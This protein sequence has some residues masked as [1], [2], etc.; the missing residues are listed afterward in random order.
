M[1]CFN[2]KIFFISLFFTSFLF[3]LPTF[4]ND[5]Y[6]VDELAAIIQT[7]E[8]FAGNFVSE[9]KLFI[10]HALFKASYKISYDYG[11]VIV[12][13]ATAFIIFL[14]GVSIYFIGKEVKSEKTGIY[15]AF[16]Y[17]VLISSF[18][19]HFMATN[20]EII[21]NLPISSGI[22]F[23]I[24]AIKNFKVQK[25]LYVFLST[26]AYFISAYVATNVK[27]HGIILIII[28]LFYTFA[29]IPYIMFSGKNLIKY[30]ISFTFIISIIFTLDI[31]FFQKIYP[32]LKSIMIGKLFYSFNA[33][34]MN[35]FYILVKYSHRQLLLTL[36][37]FVLWIPVF[38]YLKNLIF[39][40]KFKV[41]IIESI[42]VSYF[43]LTYLMVFGGG[44]RL[45]FHYFMAPYPAACIL[46][47]IALNTH[48]SNLN[49][50]RNNFIK[51]LLIPGLFFFSWNTKDVIIKHFFPNAYYNE[52]KILYWTRAV[53][54][55]TFDDYL[56]PEPTYNDAAT[57]LKNISSPNDKLFVWGNGP[58]LYYFSDMRMATYTLWP[59]NSLLKIKKEYTKGNYSNG[60]NKQK[61]FVS[62][63]KQFKPKYYADTSD[64]KLSESSKFFL[65]PEEFPIINKYFIDNFELIHKVD[66]VKIY[67]RK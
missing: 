43:L 20:G 50:F 4:F 24:L 13:I 47:G 59:Q 6:D 17:C 3:R 65:K 44:S 66:G 54:V 22:L 55:G 16:L 38:F 63:I 23:L 29:Y 46:A 9:S 32:V 7:K 56:L 53:L 14:T 35:P 61:S 42:I 52:G 45:Y 57:Y 26:I 37:H 28:T 27:F 21:Y 39:K 41:N 11:W 18:N 60:D 58:Y 25:Y 33:R 49:K 67:K 12:H 5:Y 10:Y 40:N 19:R 36:W 15:G 31:F 48:N 1:K 30:F 8:H 34:S 62:M 51:Y 64:S 2:K